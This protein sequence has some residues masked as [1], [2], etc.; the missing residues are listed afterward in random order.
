MRLPRVPL[1]RPPRRALTGLC[2]LSAACLAGAVSAQESS[3][4]G[5][6]RVVS[7]SAGSQ[8]V[9]CP[10][11][12]LAGGT[13]TGCGSSAVLQISAD[14]SFQLTDSA[15]GL[16]ILA[17]GTWTAEGSIVVF[18]LV[19]AGED[20]NDNGVVDAGEL[21]PYEQRITGQVVG[22][23]LTLLGYYDASD[24]TGA[25]KRA[26]PTTPRGDLDG[27]GRLDILDVL[28]AL[29]IAAG[30]VAATPAQLV[31]GDVNGDGAVNVV[32]VL[33]MLRAL[34]GLAPL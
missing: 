1:V 33:Q 30:L 8:V 11:V 34:A 32:D 5:A 23:D 10:G 26:A 4:V 12:L 2:L 3:P 21:K 31:A 13:L 9:T 7:L 19:E 22:D 6:W 18:N 20:D 24:V 15:F 28:A 27:S 16:T 14:G 25:L 29:R 17:R